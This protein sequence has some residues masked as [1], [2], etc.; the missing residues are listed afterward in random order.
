M[1]SLADRYS[2]AAADVG[3]DDF[4]RAMR[5]AASGVTVVTTDGV[6]GRV[7]V[8]VSAVTPVSADPPRILACINRR[9]PACRAIRANRA[10]AINILAVRH[11]SVAES[12]SGRPRRGAAFDFDLARWDSGA[13]RAPMLRGALAAIDCVPYATPDAGTHTVFFG[14]VVAVRCGEGRPLLYS[15]RGYGRFEPLGRGTDPVLEGG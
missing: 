6:A 15:D 10:F 3:H 14:R 5:A 4:I 8:T 7:G 9:S 13:T 12:F 2:D 1:S 11:Q